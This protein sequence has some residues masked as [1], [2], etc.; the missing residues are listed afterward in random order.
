MPEVRST[1]TRPVNGECDGR[2]VPERTPHQLPRS[3]SSQPQHVWAFLPECLPA[4]P[5][6]LCVSSS[7]PLLFCTN[8][9]KASLHDCRG[10]ALLTLCRKEAK[11]LMAA[12][13][14]CIKGSS[15]SDGKE[16]R[17]L[18]RRLTPRFSV[19]LVVR[20]RCT[21]SSWIWSMKDVMSIHLFSFLVIISARRVNISTT[22][23]G[24]WTTRT[25]SQHFSLFF[26]TVRL[27]NETEAVQGFICCLTFCWQ[28]PRTTSFQIR[29]LA[30]SSQVQLF[31]FQCQSKVVMQICCKTDCSQQQIWTGH[32]AL[33]AVTGKTNAKTA[34][35]TSTQEKNQ[36]KSSR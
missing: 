5:L 17:A 34:A 28:S 16:I 31:F 32:N 3:L 36:L 1:I 10:S 19:F 13:A 29:I 27:V 8:L 23:Q 4:T 6:F 30:Q 26:Q 14:W 18:C 11:M 9:P 25:D 12:A 15:R 21:V 24:S 35:N 20:W 2:N 7:L 33:S 22:R